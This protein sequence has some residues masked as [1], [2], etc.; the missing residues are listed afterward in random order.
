MPASTPF[1]PD[2]AAIK[3]YFLTALDLL[4]ALPNFEKAVEEVRRSYG[5]KPSQ[6]TRELRRV[7]PNQNLRDM[8]RACDSADGFNERPY[9]R[10]VAMVQALGSSP[11]PILSNIETVMAAQSKIHEFEKDKFPDLD[12][13]IGK[14]RLFDIGRVPVS[15][16][17]LLKKYV[18]YGEN[19]LYPFKPYKG[20][21][22]PQLKPRV[23]QLTLEPYI[24]IRIYADTD[25][26]RPTDLHRWARVLQKA[27]PTSPSI[28]NQNQTAIMQAWVYYTLT[29]RQGLSRKEA[30][31]VL[32]SYG[33]KTVALGRESRI[34][35]RFRQLGSSWLKQPPKAGKKL[36]SS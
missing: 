25:L 6:L 9:H 17:S 13:H 29:Q 24:E 30:N 11:K 14:L 18:L 35:Q 16:H 32:V 8:A 10:H 36:A 33:L 28:L 3:G 31:R 1:L 20:A 4:R 19:S 22:S 21:L 34:L 2:P 12:K 23:D 27:L 7:V 15:W 5:I 26:G